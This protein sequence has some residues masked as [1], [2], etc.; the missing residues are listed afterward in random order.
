MSENIGVFFAEARQAREMTI[1]DV[2]EVLHIKAEY[3]QAIENGQFNFNLPDIYKRGF[4]KSYAS[5]LCLDMEEM[6]GK[7]PIRPFETLESSQRR[8]EMVSQVAKKTQT[9]NHDH[10]KTSFSDDTDDSTSVVPSEKVAFY[11]TDAFKIAGVIVASGALL[12]LILRGIIVYFSDRGLVKVETV[13]AVPE[14]VQKRIVMRSNGEVKIIARDEGDKTKVFSGT[15]L[16]GEEKIITYMKPI[17]I[18]F[19]RGESLVIEMDNGEHLHP[20][21]GRGGLRIK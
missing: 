9:V 2:A 8:R 14:V 21:S 18:Y 11:K 3:V 16:K 5:F 12:L 17:Q 13:E 4:F 1:D 19:D 20:E 15:L 7:C 10:I 6:M